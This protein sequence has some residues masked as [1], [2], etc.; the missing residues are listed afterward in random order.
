M[1]AHFTIEGPEEQVALIHM[2]AEAVYA[3]IDDLTVG[4]LVSGSSGL[5]DRCSVKDCTF[6]RYPG[7]KTCSMH[8]SDRVDIP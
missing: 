7:S 2:V 3:T 4:D 1:T 6:D 5:F 8:F